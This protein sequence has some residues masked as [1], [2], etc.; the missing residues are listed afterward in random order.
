[1]KTIFR[2][3]NRVNNERQCTKLQC[4]RNW[5]ETTK[6]KEIRMTLNVIFSQ[7]K[8]TNIGEQYTINKDFY[9]L[10]V[11]HAVFWFLASFCM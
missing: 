10:Q 6:A 9:R 3:R 2:N 1:M 7:K 11:R 4:H 8:C 5:R